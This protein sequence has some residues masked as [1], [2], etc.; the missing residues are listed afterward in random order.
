MSKFILRAWHSDDIPAIAQAANNEKIASN[1]R[2]A[3]P[4]P[5]SEEDARQFICGC[6]ERGEN[7]QITRAIIVDG[8]AVGSIGVFLGKD[9]YEK[10]AEVG[11]WLAEEYWGQGIMTAAVQQ[12]CREAFDKFDIVRIYAEPFE[13]N[14][15]SR[16]V[17]EKSGFACEGVMRNGAFKN[18]RVIS[19]CMYALLH[20]GFEK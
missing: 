7:R 13:H 19:F 8:H 16:R 2:N 15:G 14:T 5:Y 1:L 4:Y 9:I 10:T 18:G 6:I 17:L 11:Y 20:P 3:F 12:I